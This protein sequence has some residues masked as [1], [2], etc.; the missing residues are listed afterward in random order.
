MQAGEEVSWL[1]NGP[2]G[3]GTFYVAAKPTTRAILQKIATEL[4][5]S[6]QAT[7]TAPTGPMSKLRKPRIGL[8][9]STAAT[10]PVRLDA[11]DLREL[12][13]PVREETKTTCSRR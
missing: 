4:G 11:A 12:R 9:D 1:A 3:Y 7:P 2:M 8:V 6:F 5:I 13:V 10:M